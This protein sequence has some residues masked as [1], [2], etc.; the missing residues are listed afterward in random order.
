MLVQ[1]DIGPS[2]S[3]LPRVV[4]ANDEGMMEMR[5]G[6]DVPRIAGQGACAETELVVDE[7]SDD[8]FN[9][10]LRKSGDRRQACRG[11]LR[12]STPWA[13]RPNYGQTPVPNSFDE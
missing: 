9:D 6:G 7:I 4:G 12:R 1:N 11:S 2:E 5:D 8:D 3:S 13:H 10:V